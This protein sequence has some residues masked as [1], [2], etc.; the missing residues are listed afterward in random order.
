MTFNIRIFKKLFGRNSGKAC[1]SKVQVT[2]NGFVDTAAQGVGASTAANYRTAVR[3]FIR[4]NGNRDVA[5]SAIT[6]DKVGQY[7]RWLTVNCKCHNTSSCYLR[8]LRAVYNK[9]VTKHK[10]RNCQPFRG[11]FTGNE[12]T[13]NRGFKPADIRKLRNLQLPDGSSAAF[14]CDLF[15][16]SFYAMGMPP[17]D[18]A[19][20][21]W[22]KIKG[23]TLTYCRHKTG[24]QVNVQIEPCMKV[25]IERHGLK[26]SPFIFP[27]LNRKKGTPARHSLSSKGS[28]E[29]FGFSS[30][31]RSYNRTLKHLAKEAGIPS[32]ISSYVPRHSWASFAYARN[33]GLP[34]ISKALGHS[35]T[36]TTMLYINEIDNQ[37]VAKANR[38][39][40]REV[41]TSAKD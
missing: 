18:L 6:A 26:D 19:H 24:R 1:K 10:V 35:N 7:E 28:G 25:I 9:A 34:V 30:F 20:L 39:L 31:L 3:S 32:G 4:F 15:L 27:I 13:T 36:K 2:L 38:K 41:F 22:S 40:L 11:T 5:L 14:A 17:I 37:L 23:N 16:F 8:S 12:P 33:I 21:R 29:A